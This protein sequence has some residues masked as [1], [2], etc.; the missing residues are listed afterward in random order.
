MQ[1]LDRWI[2]LRFVCGISNTNPLSSLVIPVPPHATS[3]D[4]SAAARHCQLAEGV[5]STNE[6]SPL[7]GSASFPYL[8]PRPTVFPVVRSATISR[9]L[10]TTR[11]GLPPSL[12]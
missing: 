9:H 4:A 11:S 10:L 7:T 5:N 1:I 8:C 12:T 3:H 2:A 6:P